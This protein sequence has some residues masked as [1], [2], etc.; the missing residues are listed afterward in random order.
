MLAA[1]FTGNPN[2]EVKEWPNPTIKKD[3][4]VLIKVTGCGICGTDMHILDPSFGQSAARNIV[5]G[6]E[7]VG[8]V[9]EW[10]GAVSGFEKGQ[11]VLVNAHPGCGRCK[12][13][14]SGRPDLCLDLR[15][16]PVAPGQAATIGMYSDGGMAPYAVVPYYA[17][18]PISKEVPSPIA[19]LAEPLAC[20]INTMEKAVVRPGDTAAVLGCGPIGLMFICMLKANGAYKIIASDVSPMRREAALRCGA[21]HVVDPSKTTV[22]EVVAKE[23]AGEG[24]DIAVEAVGHLLP[25]CVDIACNGGTILQFGHDESAMVTIHASTLL[26]KSLHIHGAFLDVEC[27]PKVVRV[28]ESGLLPLSEVISHVLPLSKVNEGLEL[29]RSGKALKVIIQPEE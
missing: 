14:L 25:D 2:L 27:F 26:R 17:L 3:T 23:T 24:V 29:I 20:V 13:C 6:H 5:L 1:I 21:T 28:L 16:N 19:A 22:Q 12:R 15:N 9:L 7:F 8:E 10:G 18:Y 4:D 11:S